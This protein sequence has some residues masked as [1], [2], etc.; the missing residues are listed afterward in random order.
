MTLLAGILASS[1]V[2]LWRPP[3][4]WWVR[5]RL[6][7]NTAPGRSWIAVALV[8]GAAG[9]P[10]LPEMSALRIALGGTVAALGVF[11]VRQVRAGRERSRVAAR[12]TEVLE[13][14]VLMGAELRAGVLPARM[15]AGLADDFPVLVPA[16]RAA[17]L[18]GDVAGVLR[19]AAATPGRGLLRDLGGA[20]Q[21]AERSGAPLASVLT[22]LAEA[23][24]IEQ[25]IAREA[26]AGVAPARAT[27][28]LMAVL[29][30]FGLLLG[31]G[32]GG[33]PVEVLLASWI[34]VFCLAT[35]CGLACLGLVW[36]E[37]IA[38]SAV[39]NP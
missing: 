22:R 37:R 1:C 35:G 6:G 24:R 32:M 18:G 30:A 14:V 13:L 19:D 34:G 9:M 20:W 12:R 2:L 7:T 11:G 16:A 31:S 4:R 26:Q 29:P 25:D 21:V 36:I 39:E 8:V 23:T 27:G 17:E 33:N 28:R 38:G 5:Q 15:L 10:W 3:G